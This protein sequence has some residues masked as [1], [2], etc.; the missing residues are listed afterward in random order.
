[1]LA[2]IIS[3]VDSLEAGAPDRQNGQ[4]QVLSPISPV[5]RR[6]SPTHYAS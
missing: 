5:F 3:T 1:M 4:G 2:L 6:V